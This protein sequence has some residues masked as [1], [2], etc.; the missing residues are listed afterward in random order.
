[1]FDII[2]FFV[3]DKSMTHID[4]L[5]Q[6]HLQIGENALLT[7]LKNAMIPILYAHMNEYVCVCFVYLFAIENNNGF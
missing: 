3:I 1:M 2:Y 7:L 5:Q 6:Q 4:I